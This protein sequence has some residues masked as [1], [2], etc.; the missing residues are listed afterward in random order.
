VKGK[1]ANIMKILNLKASNKQTSTLEIL[2]LVDIHVAVHV[3]RETPQSWE[4]PWEGRRSLMLARY[5]HV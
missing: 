5:I 1:E 3:C 4:I 2:L